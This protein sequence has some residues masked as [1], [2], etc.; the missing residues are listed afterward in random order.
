MSRTYN[1]QNPRTDFEP[2]EIIDVAG[3]VLNG[4]GEELI[5]LNHALDNIEKVR[6]QEE[7]EELRLRDKNPALKDAWDH[8]QTTMALVK[9]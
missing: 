1:L 3:E 6:L 9:K 8:Y 4:I 7:L 5:R 2:K